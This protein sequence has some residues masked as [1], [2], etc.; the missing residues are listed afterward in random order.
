MV[1]YF[2]VKLEHDHEMLCLY[3]ELKLTL[4]VLR[5]LSKSSQKMCSPS[6]G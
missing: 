4:L 3:V 6:N 1:Q 2:Y 5:R